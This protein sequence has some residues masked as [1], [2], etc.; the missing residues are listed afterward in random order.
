MEAKAE[1]D[2]LKRSSAERKTEIKQRL[3]ALS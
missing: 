2:A 1:A 3:E